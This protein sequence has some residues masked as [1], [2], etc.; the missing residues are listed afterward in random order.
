[1]AD[2][3]IATG[4][5][6]KKQTT[7]LLNV[8]TNVEW[9]ISNSGRSAVCYEVLWPCNRSELLPPKI[10]PESRV[11]ARNLVIVVTDH[12]AHNKKIVVLVD[13]QLDAQF[14]LRYVY[15]NPLHVSSNY[16][17]IFRKTIVLTL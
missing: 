6:W 1:V 14:L 7:A 13:N 15:L 5:D 2:K 12:L 9:S 4:E 10:E 16:V 8:S 3:G 17:L 11:I